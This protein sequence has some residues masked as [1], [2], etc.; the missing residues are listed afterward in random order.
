MKVTED[1]LI[2]AAHY[3]FTRRL[4]EVIAATL[5]Y[6]RDK[7]AHDRRL[8]DA[9]R[10]AAVRF[11]ADGLA[12]RL[13]PDLGL[14]DL[15]LEQDVA[16]QRELQRAA[17]RLRSSTDR[18]FDVTGAA[19]AD[20]VAAIEAHDYELDRPRLL[21]ALRTRVRTGPPGPDPAELI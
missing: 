12:D 17:A 6:Q 8:D 13:P 9:E 5:S 2:L 1:E 7:R 10:T 16:A 20:L 11:T 19:A 15:A 4:S 14:L 18:F 21:A 3:G